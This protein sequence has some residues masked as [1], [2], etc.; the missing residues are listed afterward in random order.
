M[1]VLSKPEEVDEVASSIRRS[2]DE[3][4]QQS[5]R[6]RSFGRKGRIGEI[7]DSVPSLRAN[8][9]M[10]TA[11][12]VCGYEVTP[13]RMLARRQTG[14]RV[15]VGHGPLALGLITHVTSKP[16]DTSL[17]TPDSPRCESA[18]GHHG[19]GQPESRCG[20]P[21][22]VGWLHLALVA[23]PKLNRRTSQDREWA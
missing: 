13:E 4:S 18:V 14:P 7:G 9:R 11:R 12:V 1:A 20:P 23:R 22:S 16:P 5:D 10:R 21:K 2:R 19:S 3:R 8:G 15:G 6:R 17:L